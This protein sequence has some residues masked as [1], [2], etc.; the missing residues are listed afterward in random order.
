MIGYASIQVKKDG[1]GLFVMGAIKS[2]T[3]RL[4]NPTVGRRR[5]FQLQPKKVARHLT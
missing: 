4:R 5:I 1:S 2:G 3:A